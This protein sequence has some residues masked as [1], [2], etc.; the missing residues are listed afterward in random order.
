M[1]A[2]SIAPIFVTALSSEA[3]PVLAIVGPTGSGKSDL[4]LH[5]A[6]QFQGEII[7]CDSIQVYSG[8]DIG[9]AKTPIAERGDIPHHLIDVISPAD[10]LTAGAYSRLAR[11]ALAGIQQCGRL[12]VIVGGTGLYLRAFID[13]LVAAPERDVELR[14]RL[15]AFCETNSP[16]LHRFLRRFDPVAAQ[17]IHPNDRQKL[18]RAVELTITGKQPASTTQQNRRNALTGVRVLKIGLEPDR[19]ALH[20]VLNDRVRRMFS[21]GLVAETSRLLAHGAPPEAK[22]LQS[23][24][25]KQALAVLQGQIDEAEAIEQCQ[26]KTRQYAKRQLTWFRHEP[27][28]HWLQGFGN[29]P[30]I[31]ASAVQLA[32]TVL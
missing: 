14:K 16:L 27:G 31:Q 10:E 4:G 18:M 21:D 28:V 2:L 3:Y 5:L 29:N 32:R 13:G 25:Y 12:P 15:S 1:F 26:T 20:Q 9:S 24:G 11:A 6:R 7:S 30:E 17:R 23:L 19:K 22:S 8:L